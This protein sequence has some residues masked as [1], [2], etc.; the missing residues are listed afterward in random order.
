MLT[1]LDFLKAGEQW[2]PRSEKY[3]LDRYQDN[4]ALFE[5]D[6]AEVY[7]EQFKRI[8]RVIGNFLKWFLMQCYSTIRS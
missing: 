4:R 2:P 7:K 6:H 1:S 8:E 3:R 5:D